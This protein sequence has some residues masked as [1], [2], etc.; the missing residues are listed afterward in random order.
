[1]G[2]PVKLRDCG[3]LWARQAHNLPPETVTRELNR[4]CH[5]EA[6]L[7]EGMQRS[8]IAFLRIGNDCADAG[9]RKDEL[10]EELADYN[11]TQPQA[12][13]FKFSDCEVDTSRSR[14]RSELSGMLWVVS[15][16]IPLNP[17]D[18]LAFLFDHEHVRRLGTV[19]ARTVFRLNTRQIIPLVPPGSH[20]GGGEPFLKQWEVTSFKWPE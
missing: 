3:S 11:R 14:F 12:C 16:E 6:S 13:H 1:V 20:V 8:E 9:V 2:I 5:V 19:N 10:V 15:P 7:P 18:W 17:A 4:I